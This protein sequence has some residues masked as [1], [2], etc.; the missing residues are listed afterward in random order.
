MFYVHL[1]SSYPFPRAS[2]TRAVSRVCTR[3]VSKARRL[4]GVD[5]TGLHLKCQRCDVAVVLRL[6]DSC[7]YGIVVVQ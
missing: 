7:V 5:V 1:S 6:A 3:F 2:H 4:V